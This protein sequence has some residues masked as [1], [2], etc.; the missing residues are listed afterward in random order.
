MS[1]RTAKEKERFFEE[2]DKA[3]QTPRNETLVLPQ[4]EK[5]TAMENVP[6]GI[7]GTYKRKST[8]E[9]DDE[10]KRR[11]ASEPEGLSTGVGIRSVGVE[12]S[13]PRRSN[14]SKIRNTS[15][16]SPENVTRED[17]LSDLLE[18]MVLFFIPNSTK[19]GV[20]RFRMNLFARHGADVRDVWNEDITHIICDSN[21]T[22]E[23]VMRTLRWEQIPVMTSLLNLISDRR[24]CCE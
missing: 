2:L 6:S 9:E 10:T 21:I 15:Q 20:R 7:G 19:N 12:R 4:A 11:R 3:F 22:G 18:G 5:I 14:S 23:R 1:W 13:K 16:Q 8:G 24:Y 17:R